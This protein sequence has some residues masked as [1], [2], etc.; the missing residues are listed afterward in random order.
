MEGIFLWLLSFFTLLFVMAILGYQMM[1]LTDLELEDM[2]TYDSAGRINKTVMLE[3]TAQATSCFI[4]LVS[5]R[6]VMLL[7]SAPYLYY[8]IKLYKMGKHLVD[9]TEIHNQLEH[10]R[11][12]RLIKFG[13]LC[14]I[15]VLSLF[16]VIWSVAENFEG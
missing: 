4:F 8:N 7:L 16:W 12:R 9:V 1:C 14:I 2:S 11:N 10:E 13:Y 15:V 5:G 6:W 3:M